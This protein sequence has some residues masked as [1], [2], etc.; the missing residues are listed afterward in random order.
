MRLIIFAIAGLAFAGAV[1]TGAKA[2]GR[3]FQVGNGALITI[4]TTPDSPTVGGAYALEKPLDSSGR[5]RKLRKSKIF[6]P[7]GGHH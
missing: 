4:P 7:N 2:E 6:A 1:G 3:L 5:S